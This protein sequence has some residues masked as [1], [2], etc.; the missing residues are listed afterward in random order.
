[1]N[2]INQFLQGI[3]VVDLSRHLPGP[4]ASLMMLDLGARVIKVEPPGGEELRFIGPEGPNGYSGYF[5]SVNSGKLGVQL[6]L[7][8]AEGRAGRRWL[9]FSS[10]GRRAP[11]SA[12]WKIRLWLPW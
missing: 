4:L 8:T 12:I 10:S 3:K 2:R 6:N 1:M 9:P 7:K 11:C 5:D